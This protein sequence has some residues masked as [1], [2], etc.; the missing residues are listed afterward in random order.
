[1]AQLAIDNTSKVF[2]DPQGQT[3]WAVKD[4][5]FEVADGGLLVLVGPS[6]CGKTTLLRMIAGLEDITRG[7]ISIGGY[8][9]NQVPP[10][11]RNVAMVF[12]NLALYPH[13]TAFENLALGLKLR[14][15]PASEIA[16]SVREVAEWLGLADCLGRRPGELSGGE[17][18]R[19]AVGRALVR[20]PSILLLDEPLSNLDAPLR[21][22]MRAEIS[23]WQA[24]LRVTMIYVTHDQMDALALGQRIAVMKN[25]SIQQ[26]ADP[27]ALYYRP[28]NLF[29]AGFIGPSPMNLLRGVIATERGRLVFAVPP[30]GHEPT[31]RQWLLDLPVERQ[32]G[33]ARLLGQD[34]V[35]GLRPEHVR[36]R[37]DL[38]GSTTAAMTAVVECAELAG[39]GMCL[40]LR[41][42]VHALT[43]RAPD[44]VKVE[45]NETVTVDFDTRW[46]QFFDPHSGQALVEGS[47]S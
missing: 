5:T 41:V 42:G 10:R 34:V 29:V 43:A 28:A 7:T 21:A 31:R 26:V 8:A 32:Q 36:L 24:R 47:G 30:P 44:T 22:Q 45:P 25:G 3:I 38:A 40:R 19:V 13:L 12:Q 15:E 2:L 20:K 16:R 39:P 37:S 18:Q 4:V 14:K 35:L 33:L 9:V 46:A 1:V 6:G 11:D 23:K 27:T 17:R